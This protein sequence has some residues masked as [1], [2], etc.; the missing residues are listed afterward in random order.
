LGEESE[1]NSSLQEDSAVICQRNVKSQCS[2]KISRNAT[3]GQR[4]PHVCLRSGGRDVGRTG[5]NDGRDV[6]R[7]GVKENRC[8]IENVL[9]DV[10][11]FEHEVTVASEH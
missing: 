9:M 10:D 7:T 3:T 6:G 2:A 8:V 11:D 4:K 1:P 5:A